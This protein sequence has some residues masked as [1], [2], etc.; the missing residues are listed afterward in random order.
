MLRVSDP[1]EVRR[2]CDE[3]RAA[4]ERV[5]LVPTMG[6]LHEGHLSLVRDARERSDFLVVSIF[7]NPTQFGPG[8]DLESYPRDMEGDLEKCRAEGVDL[9]F[10]PGTEDLYPPGFQTH[11]EVERLTKGMCGASRPTHFRGVATVVTKLFNIVGPCVAVFGQKD[12]QQLQVIK[13]MVADL[14]MPVEVV[15][16]PTV[17]E[18]DGLAKSS[19]NAYLTPEQRKSATCLYRSLVKL[20]QTVEREGPLDADRAVALVREVIEAEDGTDIDYVEVRGAESLEPA[21]TV[22]G[23]EDVVVAMAVRLG[24]ARLIDNMVFSAGMG[25]TGHVR[26]PL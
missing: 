12:Y 9:V 10:A 4:G 19:R 15:G 21:R 14:N 20:R 2:I 7:V 17:R 23:D 13:R 26:S 22:G 8:E 18:P 6:Y 16:H 24:R 25:S 1:E 5:G 3:R 11:V